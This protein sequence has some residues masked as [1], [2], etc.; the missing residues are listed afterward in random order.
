MDACHEILGVGTV[1]IDNFIFVEKYPTSDQKE[2]IVAEHRS[3]GGLVGTA[4]ATAARFGGRCVYWGIVGVES[5]SRSVIEGLSDAGIECINLIEKRGVHAVHSYI[6]AD[7]SLHTRTIF[8]SDPLCVMP[9]REQIDKSIFKTVKVLLTDQ[10]GIEAARYAKQL[11][12]PVVADMDWLGRSDEQ[13]FMEIVDHLVLS[14][15]FARSVVNKDNPAEIVHSLQEI[16]DRVCTAVT[17]GAEG[18]YF[19]SKTDEDRVKRIPAFN[20][21]ARETTGC[22]D[23]FHGAY[24]FALTLNYSI[25]ECMLFASAA[26]SLYASRPSGWEHL[27]NLT[28]VVDL[29]RQQQINI[30]S[31]D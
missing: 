18:C 5:D 29:I 23:V 1:T 24:A 26:S 22:G 16:G 11:G 10:T 13:E 20:V 31:I 4:L 19:S 14:A 21:P 8:F 6:I 15:E 7:E 30:E 28:E 27:P 9:E 17:F 12:I 2:K 3:F 25:H